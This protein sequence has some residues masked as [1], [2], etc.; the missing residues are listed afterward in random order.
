L[1]K[2]EFRTKL[3]QSIEERN[4]LSNINSS[5]IVEKNVKYYST[6]DIEQ[7]FQNLNE[8]K[9]IVNTIDKTLHFGKKHLGVAF[10]LFNRQI[11]QNYLSALKYYILDEFSQKQTWFNAD[12]L[13][14]LEK[15]YSK[16]LENE[17][18]LEKMI[19]DLELVNREFVLKAQGDLEEKISS[20]DKNSKKYLIDA[21]HQFQDRI[22]KIENK[23]KINFDYQILQNERLNTIDKNTW[24]NKIDVQKIAYYNQFPKTERFTEYLWVV[25][26][27]IKK[28]KI[29]DVGCVESIFPQEL[30][31]FKD[32]EVFGI[33]TRIYE[34]TKFKFYQADIR[35]TSFDDNYFDQI[36]IISTLEHIG[37]L[38]Y[39][40][41]VLDKKGDFNTIT[42]VKRVLKAGGS[43]LV[44]I[45]FGKG[46]TKWFRTYNSKKIQDLFSDFSIKELKFFSNDDIVWHEIL[47]DEAELVDNSEIVNCIAVIKAKLENK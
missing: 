20:V 2:E 18:N 30:I 47:K 43:V 19:S 45:P 37:L 32:L 11:T 46:G 6:K 9:D 8:N 27:L 31:K 13:K 15:L 34:N 24:L 29:L 38:W 35:N 22:E 33:D 21:Q 42:E 39:D 41:D 16:S 17:Q 7:I 25:K 26:H 4:E 44:T 5:Q 23:L 12:T 1:K 14:T 40:N 28:G 10:Y 36:T 3:K